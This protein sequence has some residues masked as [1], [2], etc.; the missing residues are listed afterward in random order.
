[1]IQTVYNPFLYITNIPGTWVFR[2]QSGGGEDKHLVIR[3]IQD[4]QA[5]WCEDY[6]VCFAFED[7]ATGNQACTP[8]Y[9]V[10]YNPSDAPLQPEIWNQ[11]NREKGPR[12]AGPWIIE[13]LGHHID[14]LESFIGVAGCLQFFDELSVEQEVRHLKE[15]LTNLADQKGFEELFLTP[16]K[17]RLE[18]LIGEE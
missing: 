15:E 2:L 5:W 13:N 3:W 9:A 17:H 14:V 16:Q 1:M 4:K 12:P 10:A 11:D 18:G 8:V 6:G 7:D